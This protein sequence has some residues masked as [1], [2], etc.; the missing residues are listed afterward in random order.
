MAVFHCPGAVPPQCATPG[1]SVHCTLVLLLSMVGLTALVAGRRKGALIS[2]EMLRCAPHG[3]TILRIQPDWFGSGESNFVERGNAGLFGGRMV[4]HLE[5]MPVGQAVAATKA[6]P[7]PS[8]DCF[9]HPPLAQSLSCGLGPH[10]T[11]CD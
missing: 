9:L 3:N 4:R 8:S 2:H 10:I 7:I 6:L 1:E 5:C 11:S